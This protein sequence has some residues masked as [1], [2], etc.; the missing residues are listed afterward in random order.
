MSVR[1][2]TSDETVNALLADPYFADIP[3]LTRRK[4]QFDNTIDVLVNAITLAGTVAMG[5]MTGVV[6]NV[7]G[8]HFEKMMLAVAFSQNYLA[9]A[10]SE[11][12]AE[13]VVEKAAAMLHMWT[14][15]NLS[16]PLVLDSID[17]IA[18]EF[19]EDAGKKLF[20]ATF[21]AQGGT[22]Y[23]LPQVATPLV[24]NNAG[25]ITITCATAGAA[26][27]YT[28]DGK[29]PGPRN[30]TL[31]TGPFTPGAGLTLKTRAWLAGYLTSD[32]ASITT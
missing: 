28:L 17:E 22:A 8:I 3:I 26:I 12:D 18:P 20:A 10:D 21:I 23:T 14:P 7:F 29:H 24:V 1:V 2:Q 32:Q 27:F 11:P 6:K 13:D 19:S 31:Y 16:I 30:A 25:T 5:R 15:A 9:K 4:K